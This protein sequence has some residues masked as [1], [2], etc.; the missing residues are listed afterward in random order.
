MGVL[1]SWFGGEGKGAVDVRLVSSDGIIVT[2]FWGGGEGK[3]L[4][5]LGMIQ[6]NMTL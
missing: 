1:L 2:Y 5:N 6:I 3:M 4:V